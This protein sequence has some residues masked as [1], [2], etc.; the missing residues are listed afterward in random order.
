MSEAEGERNIEGARETACYGRDGPSVRRT[1]GQDEEKE[2]REAFRAWNIQETKL[3]Q[4]KHIPN[5]RSWSIS[6]RYLFLRRHTP[7]IEST[8]RKQPP[9]Y[10]Y[11]TFLL[12][13]FCELFC[14]LGGN[15]ADYYSI[16]RINIG[17]TG[18]FLI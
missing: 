6:T 15:N 16:S 9:N 3:G 8:G 13:L 4:A 14:D 12:S 11:P 17:A 7:D 18:P 10:P 5:A 1:F 2:E